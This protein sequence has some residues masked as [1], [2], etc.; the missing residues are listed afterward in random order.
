V[1]NIQIARSGRMVL[2][3]LAEIVVGMF[4]AVDVRGGQFM[5]D[6]LR[7]GK[8]GKHQQDVHEP[9]RKTDFQ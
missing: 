4:M 9:D 8:R 2:D 1:G 7:N 6:I 5:V 3:P